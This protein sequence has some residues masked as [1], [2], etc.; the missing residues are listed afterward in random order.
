MT[1][2]RGQLRTWLKSHDNKRPAGIYNRQT[3]G[4]PKSIIL[5]NYRG[6]KTSSLSEEQRR[7]DVIIWIFQYYFVLN[8]LCKPCSLQTHAPADVFQENE[9]RQA[10]FCP[11]YVL[12][13]SA[14][15]IDRLH[16][17]NT[18]N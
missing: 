6:I 16:F 7:S 13:I 15:P 10:H 2:L 9:T 4:R 18:A 17:T 3:L 5:I 1:R 11:L 12:Y 14:K 8:G